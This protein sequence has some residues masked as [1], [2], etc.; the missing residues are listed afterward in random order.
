MTSRSKPII[1]VT[2]PK[3][4]CLSDQSG[5]PETLLKN[6]LS[7]SFSEGRLIKRA[8]LV[9][10]AYERS[11]AADSVVLAMRTRSDQEETSVVGIAGEAFAS[12]F[13]AHP[14][15]RRGYSDGSSVPRIF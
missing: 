13:G 2:V 8:Y 6:R 7:E 12:I 9:R 5:P 1:R 10:V 14:N 15:A 3:I 4:R 11:T